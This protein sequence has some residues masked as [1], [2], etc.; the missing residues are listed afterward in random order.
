MTGKAVVFTLGESDID[1]TSFRATITTLT[2]DGGPS[3]SKNIFATIVESNIPLGQ[4]YSP[5]ISA[6]VAGNAGQ[7]YVYI[8]TAV[9][10]SSSASISFSLYQ[11]GTEQYF[12]N[13]SLDKAPPESP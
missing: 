7:L 13:Q 8:A 5:V 3:V 12:L 1:G 6:R 4:V 9:T 2:K 10:L 11:E